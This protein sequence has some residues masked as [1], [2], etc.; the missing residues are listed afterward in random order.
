MNARYTIYSNDNQSDIPET[1]QFTPQGPIEAL[2][3]L[4]H[5]RSQRYE[6][7]GF[8]APIAAIERDTF[9]YR[10]KIGPL[11]PDDSNHWGYR[12]RLP[13]T[14]KII[15]IRIEKLAVGPGISTLKQELESEEVA[16]HV[17][18]CG[19]D[20]VV[21]SSAQADLD[22]AY[23]RRYDEDRKDF[24]F[25]DEVEIEAEGGDEV[26]DARGENAAEHAIEDGGLENDWLE[27]GQAMDE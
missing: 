17:Q 2:D 4:I 12:F 26:R 9:P 1:Q 10:N 25:D 21:Y 6:D 27:E 16:P 22:H 5:T 7:H 11:H 15:T 18:R 8:I 14:E 3:F 23:G 19:C 24:V 13:N 20:Y